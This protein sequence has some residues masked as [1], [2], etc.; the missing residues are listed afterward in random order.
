MQQDDAHAWA[1]VYFAENGWIPF[2]S[3]PRGELAALGRNRSNFGFLFSGGAGDAV[4]GAVKSVPTQIASSLLGALNNPVLSLAVPGLFLSALVLRW[5]YFR[6]PSSRGRLLKSL[7][8]QD[9]L[10]GQ[11]RKELLS[12]YGR[13]EKMLRH[14]TRLRR[15]PWQTVSAFA[16]EAEAGQVESQLEWF[17]RAVWQ[18][19]YDPSELPAGLVDEARRRLKAIRSALKALPVGRA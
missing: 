4:F 3:S 19:A 2:D 11:D 1:E 10:A 15:Q 5:F 6:S 16:Q 7:S 14:R 13:L 12:L 8:Y 18:A 9:K 17:T